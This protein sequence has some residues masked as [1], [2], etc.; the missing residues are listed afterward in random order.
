MRYGKNFGI[1]RGM[2][3]DKRNSFFYHVNPLRALCGVNLV[4][5][6]LYQVGFGFVLGEIG[7]FTEPGPDN[8]EKERGGENA[9]DQRRA[10]GFRPFGQKES[11]DKK[12]KDQK[13]RKAKIKKSFWSVWGRR[14]FLLRIKNMINTRLLT[15]SRLKS[16]A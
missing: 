7:R 12:E 6:N 9:S 14:S 15:K 10:Y 11:D 4:F 5:A 8:G 3:V 16:R 2:L 1:F 13:K